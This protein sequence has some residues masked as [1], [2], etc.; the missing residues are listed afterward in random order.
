MT[1]VFKAKQELIWGVAIAAA[2]S[3]LQVLSDFEPSKIVS[4]QTWAIALGAGAVRAAAGA[5][6]AFMSRP[7]SQ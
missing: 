3:V 2:V 5:A 1:Y 6:L 4:W 7:R